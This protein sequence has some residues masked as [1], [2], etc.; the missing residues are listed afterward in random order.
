MPPPS[1]SAI[2]DIKRY[3]PTAGCCESS[4]RATGSTGL[5][6]RVKKKAHQADDEVMRA[7]IAILRDRATGALASRTTPGM[8]QKM[9][10][11]M[12]ALKTPHRKIW[13]MTPSLFGLS[14][15][16]SDRRTERL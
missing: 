10:P 14:F 7:I 5:F 9:E 15:I 13:L 4:F 12:T 16:P 11:R 8:K 3:R 2:A 6:L 1:T